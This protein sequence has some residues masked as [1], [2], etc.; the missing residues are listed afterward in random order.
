MVEVNLQV[1]CKLCP[2]DDFFILVQKQPNT[3]QPETPAGGGCSCQ[4]ITNILPVTNKRQ[5]DRKSPSKLYKLIFLSALSTDQCHNILRHTAGILTLLCHLTR[6]TYMQ[7]YQ[8]YLQKFAY[9]Q[10]PDTNSTNLV[11]YSCFDE[12]DSMSRKRL[13]GSIIHNDAVFLIG[14]NLL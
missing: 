11:Y 3:E 4:Q 1:F 10:R 12:F 5:R 7:L 8:T 6:A 9:L 13:R 2:A 14:S